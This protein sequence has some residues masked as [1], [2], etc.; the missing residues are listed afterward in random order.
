MLAEVQLSAA[1]PSAAQLDSDDL[2]PDGIIL[3][4]CFRDPGD[5]ADTLDQVPFLHYVD[6]HYQS[7][8]IATKAKIPNFY[9]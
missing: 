9:T 6:I 4:R 3:V 1:S 2:E 7:T 8:N 5:A